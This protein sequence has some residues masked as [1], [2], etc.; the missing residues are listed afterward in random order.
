M[1]PREDLSK[2]SAKLAVYGSWRRLVLKRPHVRTNGIY[3]M[4]HRFLKPG[5]QMPGMP[6]RPLL[7]V[8]YYRFLRF[9]PDGVIVALTTPE[10]PD[11]AVRRVKREWA[12]TYADRDKAHPAVGS[13]D[14]N[15]TV[16]NVE[17]PMFQRKYPE[18]LAGNMHYQ[19]ALRETREG[20]NNLLFVVHHWG[21]MADEEGP[22][23][24]VIGYDS[25]QYIDRP[26]RFIPIWGFKKRVMEIF[27]PVADFGHVSQE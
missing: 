4:R 22:N 21:M 14:V 16:V 2:L 25:T 13:Y 5:T 6:F 7:H 15:D 10:R 26:F 27:P 18:M 9:Y 23:R 24:Q 1:W 11:A 12:P 20:A 3:V 17:L 19:M 8:T